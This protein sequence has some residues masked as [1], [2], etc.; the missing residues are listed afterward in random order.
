MNVSSISENAMLIMVNRL[1]RLFRKALLV[2]NVVKVIY[3]SGVSVRCAPNLDRRAGFV[4]AQ[5][6][7]GQLNLR[8]RIDDPQSSRQPTFPALCRVQVRF[9]LPFPKLVPSWRAAQQAG[10]WTMSPA[11]DDKCHLNR[12]VRL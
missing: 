10:Q 8:I 3:D 1:R 6:T 5:N 4:G 9:R 11:L 7:M 12:R 2:T